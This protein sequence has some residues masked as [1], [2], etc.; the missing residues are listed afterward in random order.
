MAWV[1]HTAF[2]LRFLSARR[3]I[4]LRLTLP[5]VC[6]AVRKHWLSCGTLH[7]QTQHT[8]EQALRLAFP[9][10]VLGEL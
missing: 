10:E 2:L 7:S 8:S 9:G 3:T 5:V 1:L 4:F 6:P